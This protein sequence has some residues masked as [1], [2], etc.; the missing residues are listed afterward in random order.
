M[1]HSAQT[2][3][4]HIHPF[5]TDSYCRVSTATGRPV[6]WPARPYIATTIRIPFMLSGIST[7]PW[8]SEYFSLTLAL[9]SDLLAFGLHGYNLYG[10]WSWG[11]QVH[12]LLVY[13]IPKAWNMT[14][15][16]KEKNILATCA[17]SV[18]NICKKGASEPEKSS[19][20]YSTHSSSLSKPGA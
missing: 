18:K 20:L 12:S 19:Y 10:A 15:F 3:K 1:T 13:W 11:R 14:M 4:H 8:E 9:T 2:R 7:L 17:F 6:H 5:F 16:N